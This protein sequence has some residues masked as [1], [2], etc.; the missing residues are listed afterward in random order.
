MYVLFREGQ[1]MVR[2]SVEVQVRVKSLKY[3]EL[4]IGGRETCC[5]LT[6]HWD[7]TAASPLCLYG[8][9]IMRVLLE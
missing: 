4:D 2:W 9:Q 5:F 3:S 6:F 7:I 1:M 8:D